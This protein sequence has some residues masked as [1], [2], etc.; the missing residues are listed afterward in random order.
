MFNKLQHLPLIKKTSINYNLKGTSAVEVGGKRPKIIESQ[1][2]F[3]KQQQ[4]Q[5]QQQQQTHRNSVKMT[6]TILGKVRK[7]LGNMSEKGLV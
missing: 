1:T 4:Q 6:K 7:A 2:H 3:S 5:Q